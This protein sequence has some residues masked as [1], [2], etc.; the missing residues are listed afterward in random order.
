MDY[1]EATDALRECATLEELAAELG[2]SV[3]RVKQAR[4][5]PSSPGH[6][7]PPSGWEAAIMRI[8]ERR[9]EQLRELA[10]QFRRG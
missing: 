6:R 4:L 10:R 3:Q 2:V 7:P 8:A 1:R 9:G 5:D